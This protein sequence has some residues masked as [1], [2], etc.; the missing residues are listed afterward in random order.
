MSATFQITPEMR[1]ARQRENAARYTLYWPGDQWYFGEYGGNGFW[2]PPDLGGKRVQHP[3]HRENGVPVMA[4][5]DGVLV[6]R[7]QYGVIYG[8]KAVPS[9]GVWKRPVLDRDGALPEHTAEKIILHFT[10]GDHGRLGVVE[11]TGD[12]EMDVMIK[13]EAKK[14]YLDTNKEWAQNELNAR[15]E[16]IAKFKKENPGLTESSAPAPKESQIRAEIM[17]LRLTT[18]QASKAAYKCECGMFEHDEFELYQMHQEARHGKKIE[19]PE[20]KAPE[21]EPSIAELVAS[22]VVIEHEEPVVKRGPG[23][24]KKVVSEG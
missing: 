16:F 22:G 9:D 13:T 19:A 23:R 10:R 6:V 11:L 1:K 2:I 17:M 14:K 12:P 15:R 3:V 20:A 7:D 4:I 21:A 24:P 5:A 18:A 8:P